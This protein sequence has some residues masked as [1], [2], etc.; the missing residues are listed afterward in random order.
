MHPIN[1][2]LRVA[3]KHFGANRVLVE[4]ALRQTGREQFTLDEAKQIVKAFASKPITK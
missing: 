2:L 3:Q 1:E 4:V